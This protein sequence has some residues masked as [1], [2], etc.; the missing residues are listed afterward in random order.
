MKKHAGEENLEDHHAHDVEAYQDIEISESIYSQ[1]F[2]EMRQAYW[3]VL[4]SIDSTYDYGM[5]LLD[6]QSFKNLVAKHLEKLLKH[7]EKHIINEFLVKMNSLYNQYDL[8]ERKATDKAT[9]IDEVILLIEFIENI[10]K[11]DELLDELEV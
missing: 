3:S 1:K 6:C 7:L 8:V 11:P 10:Q 5:I 4:T 9:T 2:Y